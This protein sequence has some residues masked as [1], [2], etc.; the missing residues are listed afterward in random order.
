MDRKRA[1]GRGLKA[2]M[3]DAPQARAG[4]VEADIDQLQANPNQPRCQF[5]DDALA[6]LAASIREHGVLQPL[7]VSEEGVGRYRILAGERRWRAARRAGLSRV[8]VVIRERVDEAEAFELALVENLQRRDLT[9]MEEARA[10]EN[11]RT[12]RGLSQAAIAERVGFDRS[13]VANALR[14]LKLPTEIQAFVEDGRLSA[15]HART[16]LSFGTDTQMRAWAEKAVA[17]GLSVR[18]LELEAAAERGSADAAAGKRRR[19]KLQTQDPNL[20]AAEEKLA[21]AIGAP[22]EIKSRGKT[23]NIVIKCKNKKDLMRIYDLVVGG[24]YGARK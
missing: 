19:G 16:L 17:E 18:H 12:E 20:R 22:V 5:D 10:Y 3:P 4:F 1:L 9:P 6:A 2:L 24:F 15:G 8:P 7:L 23:N 21:R 11:L 14:L 13:T